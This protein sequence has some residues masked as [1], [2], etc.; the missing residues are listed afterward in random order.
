MLF[1]MAATNA[2]A[3]AVENTHGTRW[4]RGNTCEVLGEYCDSM[5]LFIYLD[6]IT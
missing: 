6:N 3:D 4:K 2:A 1:Q 5:W